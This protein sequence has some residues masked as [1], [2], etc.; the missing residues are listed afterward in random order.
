VLR[1]VTLAFS[2]R[3]DVSDATTHRIH[4][5]KLHDRGIPFVTWGVWVV[6]LALGLLLGEFR[7]LVGPIDVL[8]D[9][10]RLL[11]GPLGA[12]ER[13]KHRPYVN[14]PQGDRHQL[15]CSRCS[16]LCCLIV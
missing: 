16:M 8:L 9:K 12:R 7:L 6:T 2:I 11:I 13:V 15:Y 10:F 4:Q 1:H 3:L 5:A 14:S